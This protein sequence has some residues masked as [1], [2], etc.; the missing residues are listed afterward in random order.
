MKPLAWKGRI[1]S[2]RTHAM[3]GALLVAGLAC[4][5]TRRL[6]AGSAADTARGSGGSPGGSAGGEDTSVQNGTGGRVADLG[7]DR[8]GGPDLV[9]DAV[10]LLKDCM[11]D[12]I[13]QLRIACRGAAATGGICVWDSSRKTNCFPNGVRQ[14]YYL[15]DAGTAPHTIMVTMPDGKTPCYYMDD[16]GRLGLVDY[17]DAQS[18]LVATA[19]YDVDAR[20]VTCIATGQ[21]YRIP[22]GALTDPD[23]GCPP[24]N[25]TEGSCD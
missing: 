15:S 21:V 12:C 6:D 5:A 9:G 23:A 17:F 25:C 16:P 14:V 18:V 13:A 8:Q 10:S 2:L 3:V 24:A 1:R 19:T 22:V 20:I 4:H 7:S 11:P